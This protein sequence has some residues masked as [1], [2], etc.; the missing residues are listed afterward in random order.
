MSLLM[1][2]GPPVEAQNSPSGQAPGGAMVG[3]GTIV[4][5]FDG[6]VGPDSLRLVVRAESPPGSMTPE[7]Y[8]LADRM[9]ISCGNWNG[10]TLNC[11]FPDGDRA[12]LS[13]T[14]TTVTFASDDAYVT[15]EKV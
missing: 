15:L 3:R 8:R 14:E 11:R 1:F 2:A 7:I 6:Q 10:E 5:E 13:F 4:A 12:E 9:T